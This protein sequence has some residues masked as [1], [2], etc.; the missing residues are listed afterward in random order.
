MI[1][2]LIKCVGHVP[3]SLKIIRKKNILKN[4]FS[5]NNKLSQTQL[6]DFTSLPYSNKIIKSN[7]S[8]TYRNKKC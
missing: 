3:K 6:S 5:I 7:P 8:E 4:H 1:L 2:V